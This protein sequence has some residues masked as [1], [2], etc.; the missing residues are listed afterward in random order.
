MNMDS[1]YGSGGV[2]YE[3]TVAEKKTP[4][5]T[6]KKAALIVG[7]VLW[8]AVLFLVGSATKIFVPFL[9]LVPISLWV[10]VYFTWRYTQVRYE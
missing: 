10:L 1:G 5:L 2:P 6:L 7:Y 3:F 4:L 9:A 8:A